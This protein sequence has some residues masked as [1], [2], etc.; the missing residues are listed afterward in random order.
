MKSKVTILIALTVL[1]CLPLAYW[2]ANPS[3]RGSAK[4]ALPRPSETVSNRAN[5]PP[6][7]V[8]EIPRTKSAERP[9]DSSQTGRLDDDFNP[10]SYQRRPPVDETSTLSDAAIAYVQIPSS[11]R[12]T[13]L[14]PNVLGE[15]EAQP[16][17]T[18]E[19]VGV[20]LRIEDV[21]PGTP[22]AVVILDGG[23]FPGSS[24]PSQVIKLG[25][26]SQISFRFTTSENIGYHRIRVL[27]SGGTARVFDFTASG[28]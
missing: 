13:A 7:S 6:D 24:G 21:A 3:D 27:P 20:R 11:N 16:T 22:V 17:L 15:Y 18:G 9:A 26:D 12:R 2:L 23:S 28:S 1:A 4:I 5:N 8:Q 14:L 10:T 25:R 19:T